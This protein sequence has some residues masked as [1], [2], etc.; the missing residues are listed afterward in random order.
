MGAKRPVA[1][2][3]G[4]WVGLVVVVAFE[5][6]LG[7]DGVLFDDAADL[8]GVLAAWRAEVETVDWPVNWGLRG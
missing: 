6:V 2:V 5:G 8:D 1:G 7:L 3:L 4:R